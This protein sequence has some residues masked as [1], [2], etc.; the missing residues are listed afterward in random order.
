MNI[1]TNDLSGRI[2][3]NMNRWR[4]EGI[5]ERKKE[6]TNERSKW[7]SEWTN[8]RTNEWRNE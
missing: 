5:Y 7:M 6:H 3:D 2:G 4:S 8:E 1:W